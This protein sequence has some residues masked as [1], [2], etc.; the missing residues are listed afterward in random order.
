MSLLLPALVAVPL[1]GALVPFVVGSRHPRIGRGA[2]VAVLLV[3]LGIALSAAVLVATAGSLTYVL[4]RLPAAVGIG[5]LLD[6]VSAPFVV[7]VALAGAGLYLAVREDRTGPGDALWLL[8]VAGLTGVVV[9]GDVFNLYVFLEISGLAAY[10]LVAGRAGVDRALAALRYLLVGTVG[11]TLYLLGVAYAYV[12]TGTLAMADLGPAL[13]AAGHDS[14]LVV[15]AYVLTALGLGVKL[16]LFPVHG[17]KP[18]AYAAAPRDIAALLAALGS[19]VAGY[20]LVRLTFGVFGVEF[21]RGVP[22]VR[23]GLVAVG[24]AGVVAGGYL[25]LREDDLRRLLSYSSILQFGLV[26]LALGVAT[27]AA[28]TGAI[29][30][31]LANA[32]AKGGLFVAVGHAERV[33]GRSVADLAGFGREAPLLAAGVAAAFASLVGL[34]PTVG[35]AAK[36]YIAVGAVAAGSW[37]AAA[38]VLVSTLVSLAYAGRVV[39]RL[40]LAAPAVGPAGHDGLATDGGAGGDGPSRRR[41]VAVVGIVA[42]ALVCLGLGSTAVGEWVAP[43]VEGWA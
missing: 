36:W 18:P 33:A 15:A 11:A 31:L 16:A 24:V 38:V 29:L 4:G 1:I 28:V 7:L 8:L 43:V 6:R 37:G 30:L 22:T 14:T 10:A 39:E 17:W 12:A 3:H 42:V 27:P 19:T 9:T 40:Y 26:T 34:P 23:L 21:L 13:A 41:V 32:V 35:F 25:T 20:A 5:L 2:T